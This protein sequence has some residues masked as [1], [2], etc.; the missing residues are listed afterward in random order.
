MPAKEQAGP[1]A[2][3]LRAAWGELAQLRLKND[4]LKKAAAYLAKESL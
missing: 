3:E 4:I 1:L 2:E